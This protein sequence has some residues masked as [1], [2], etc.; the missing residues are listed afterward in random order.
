MWARVFNVSPLDAVLPLRRNVFG[1]ATA[2]IPRAYKAKQHYFSRR[3]VV[4]TVV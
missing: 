4:Q 3:S 2:V 1:T